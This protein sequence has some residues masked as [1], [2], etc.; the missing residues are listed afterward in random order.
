MFQ[1]SVGDAGFLFAVWQRCWTS[2]LLRRRHGSGQFTVLGSLCILRQIQQVVETNNLHAD[3]G[4]YCNLERLFQSKTLVS[5]H[6]ETPT[7]PDF[8]LEPLLC[9]GERLVCGGVEL[10]PRTLQP[11]AL[12]AV[13][14]LFPSLPNLVHGQT[15]VHVRGRF[16]LQFLQQWP[17]LSVSLSMTGTA[18]E[19]PKKT[20]WGA[21]Y[22][23]MFVFFFADGGRLWH[24][25]KA[26]PGHVQFPCFQVLVSLLLGRQS[27]LRLQ[28]QILS[29]PLLRS[30]RLFGQLGGLQPVPVGWLQP[31]AFRIFLI[32][33]QRLFDNFPMVV[34]F[35]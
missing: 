30:S 21:L 9:H 34:R 19:A 20:I 11:A 15:L 2:L 16:V 14:D 23:M 25:H 6:L 18:F 10:Q 24:H 3:T 31:P 33:F 27:L 26:P 35:V 29:V 12:V 17:S 32:I 28:L 8:F 22:R 4:K 13:A 5:I 1:R 7:S